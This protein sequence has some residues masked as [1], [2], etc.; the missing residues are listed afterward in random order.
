MNPRLIRERA[1][2]AAKAQRIHMVGPALQAIRAK[3]GRTQASLAT[4]FH[5]SERT[6][7]RWEKEGIP[8]GPAVVL[9]RAFSDGA[10][11]P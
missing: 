2:A 4:S 5:V 1:E 7:I 6:L 10:L 11:A 9:Y 3:L 8:D